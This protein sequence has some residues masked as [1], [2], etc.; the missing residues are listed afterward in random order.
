VFLRVVRARER[1]RPTARFTTWLYRIVFNLCVNERARVSSRLAAG[2]PGGLESMA[3]EAAPAPSDGL[4]RAD[5]V[6]AVRAAIAALPETQRIAILLA[7]HDGLSHAEI[8]QVLGS[9]EK[10]VKSLVHR[11]RENLRA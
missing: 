3:D 5:A 4:E 8:A 10:A 2:E 9:T 1:Y 6:E 11:A 7:K